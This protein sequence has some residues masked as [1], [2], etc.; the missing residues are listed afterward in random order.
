LSE[1]ARLTRESGSQ[2][3]TF[4]IPLRDASSVQDKEG[5]MLAKG[6]TPIDVAVPEA[7]GFHRC[8]RAGAGCRPRGDA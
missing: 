5:I 8:R 1:Q 6:K 4:A 7:L 3:A 2:S